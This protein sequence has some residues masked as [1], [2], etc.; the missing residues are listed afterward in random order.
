MSAKPRYNVA[1]RKRGE[2][3]WQGNHCKTTHQ[4]NGKND[5]QQNCWKPEKEQTSGCERNEKCTRE[6]SAQNC[7]NV[8]APKCEQQAALDTELRAPSHAHQIKTHKFTRSAHSIQV[9][10]LATSK[11]LQNPKRLDIFVTHAKVTKHKVLLR[12]KLT[13]PI[14]NKHEPRRTKH[15]MPH[16]PIR[17]MASH[18][19]RGARE[20][21][22][23][24]ETRDR[25][26]D[27]AVRTALR[28][29]VERS[30]HFA[31]SHPVGR[32]M[33]ERMESDLWTCEAL[34]A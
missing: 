8:S 6:H 7:R 22:H 4:T 16:T 19:V 14:R 10:N 29:G 34:P 12:K 17:P 15:A 1:T 9:K 26:P 11:V 2:R 30:R 21:E 13:R 18:V 33:P 32:P 20:L 5:L 31:F 25:V 28:I 27:R 24:V 3:R 23:G